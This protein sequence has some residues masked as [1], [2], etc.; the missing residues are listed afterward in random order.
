MHFNI[1]QHFFRLS[2]VFLKKLEKFPKFLFSTK[3]DNLG[4][5]AKKQSRHDARLCFLFNLPKL[6]AEYQRYQ[7]RDK[8]RQEDGKRQIRR[9]HLGYPEKIRTY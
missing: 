2:I 5:N 8:C 6:R 4:Q 3:K 1:I 7:W 9:L